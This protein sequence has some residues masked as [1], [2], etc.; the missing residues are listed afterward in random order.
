MN[1]AQRTA[2]LR[3]V[4]AALSEVGYDKASKIMLLEGV[5]RELEG[6]K[7]AWD[8]DPEMYYM[9]IFGTPAT[10]AGIAPMRTDDTRGVLPPWPPG[11]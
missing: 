8:R 6:D 11:T 1:T 3:L 5:L 9:T 7:R 10:R 4:R 2:A